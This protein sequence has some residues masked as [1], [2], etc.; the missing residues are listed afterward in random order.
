MQPENVRSLESA[1][2]SLVEKLA[3]LSK[4]LSPEEKYVFDEIIVSASIH[5]KVVQAH[6]EGDK[7]IIFSKPKDTLSTIKMKEQYM[8]LP[9]SLGID[10]SK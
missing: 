8:Q 7:S 9:K 1:L 10:E 6:E 3:A 5:A 2:P 4:T